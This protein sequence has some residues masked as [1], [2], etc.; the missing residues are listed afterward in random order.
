VK[1]TADAVVALILGALGGF[2]FQWIG[3]PLP[4][5]LG[6]L[7][8]TACFAVA[9]KVWELP[10]AL[11]DLVRPVLGVLAGS[12]FT[13]AVVASMGQWL[14]PIGFVVLFSLLATALGWIYFA[15]LCGMDRITALFAAA[16]GG[17]GELVLMGAT[18]GANLRSLVLIHTLRVMSVVILVPLGV[19]LLL[20]HA[21]TGTPTRLGTPIDVT[22]LDWLLL[23]ASGGAG[24]LLSRS[25]RLPGGVMVAAMLVSAVLHGLGV[26][27]GAP[28]GWIVIA[29]QVVIGSMTG[30]R[31]AGIRW[32]ELFVTVLQALGW[33][34]ILIAAAAAAAWVAAIWFSRPFVVFLLALA[35]GGI[36][37]MTIITYALGVD[38]AFVVSL[39]VL[40]I[41]LVLTLTPFS[42]QLLGWGK[43]GR[44]A[45]S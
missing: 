27:H 42:F 6:S 11:R 16:P 21:V 22:W 38:V 39:H 9:G 10:V 8:A 37:E 36:A 30:A 19:S 15:K 23:L 29:V 34:L 31:F 24:Y 45:P 41:V 44:S 13:P 35:P 12:A 5:M 26:S 40:R 2:A 28:P 33:A 32:A 7:T 17:L 43:G 1:R 20:G 3:V 25:V 18:L 4:W 14:G